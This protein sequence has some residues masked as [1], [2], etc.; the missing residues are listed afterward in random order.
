MS[1]YAAG[2]EAAFET[3]LSRFSRPLY[4][5]LCRYLGRADRAEDVFQDV[6]Y[7]VIRARKSYRPRYRFAPWLFRIGRNRAVD[8]LRRNGVREMESLDRAANPRE[9][10]G[11]PRINAI[12]AGD[13]DPET[14]FH[15]RE[16]GKALEGALAGLPAD[17]REV[18]W[19]K[20]KSGLSLAEI[21]K[22]TG[23]SENTVKS[24]LRYALEKMRAA[25]AQQGFEP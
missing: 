2:D 6:F 18:L 25:L 16:L 7:E 13:P 23:V 22:I 21:A 12:A 14:L 3:L 11:D 10:D 8:R 19:L 5:F 20:E 4:S 24:R 9:D 17:Q 15:G 1:R